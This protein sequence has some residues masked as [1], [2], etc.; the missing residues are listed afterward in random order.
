[1]HRGITLLAALLLWLTMSVP[2]HGQDADAVAQVRQHAGTH[3]L[4]VLGEFHGTRETPRFVQA[5]MEAYAVEGKPLQL[6]LELPTSENERLAAYLQSNGD[7]TARRA[8][9]DSPYWGVRT[10]LHD[11]RRSHDMLDLIEAMRLLRAQGRDVRVYGFDPPAAKAGVP[12]AR[13]AAMATYLRD[14][15]AALPPSARMVV[16]TGNV[17]AMRSQPRFMDWPPMTLLLRDLELYSV[18]IEARVGEFWG[19]S[20]SQR[21]STRPLTA[22]EG[23]SLSVDTDAGRSYDLWIRLPRFT[24]ARLLGGTDL[25]CDQVP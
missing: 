24:V 25:G 13:D 9:K 22:Y 23:P 21:C 17:H 1:M 14:R 7:A 19:C 15:H 10:H 4:L 5:L 16:L 11:G 8:L 18:R 20:G 6:A 12:G 2:A 3:R